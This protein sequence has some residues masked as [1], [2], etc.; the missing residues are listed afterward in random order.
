M[1][2]LPRPPVIDLADLRGAHV[3][4]F[5]LEAGAR[6]HVH[7]QPRALARLEPQRMLRAGRRDDDLRQASRTIAVAEQQPAVGRVQRGRRLLRQPDDAAHRE[8]GGEV[9]AEHELEVNRLGLAV[10][11]GDGDPLVHAAREVALARDREWPAAQVPCDAA[12]IRVEMLRLGALAVDEQV[13]L[14]EEPRVAEPQPVP[15]DARLR[16]GAVA[17]GNGK[18]AVLLDD[19][20]LAV[21]VVL[22]AQDGVAC[23]AG[24]RAESNA[25]R[26]PNGYAVHSFRVSSSVASASSSRTLWLAR[27]ASRIERMPTAGCRRSMMWRSMFRCALSGTPGSRM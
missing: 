24:C 13:V 3:E 6:Q 5:D 26:V 9:G 7:L 8:H 15:V 17:R 16:H 12:R 10:A 21:E 22:L 2:A 19:H 11:I 20:P 18:E 4:L 27:I 23:V 25:G 1:R 14:R